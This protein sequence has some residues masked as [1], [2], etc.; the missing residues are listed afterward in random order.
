[1]TSFLNLPFGLCC[2]IFL[3]TQAS[4]A[5]SFSDLANDLGMNVQFSS[6][7]LMGGGC[8]WFDFDNDGFEDIYIT[9]GHNEDAL[10]KNNGNGT[11]TNVIFEAGFLGTS[12]K[13]TLGVVTGDID[14]DGFREVFVTTQNSGLGF[15]H[16]ENF[17]FYNNGDG[18]F[19]DIT[20]SAGLEE[21]KW[22]FSATF[23]D[24]NGDTYLDLFVGNYIETP[25]VLLDEFNN[26][27]GFGHDCYLDDLYINQGDLTF[28]NATEDMQAL[29]IGCCLA[30]A[31]TDYDGDGDIDLMAANDFG[32]WV[33]PS[34]LFEN[35]QEYLNDVSAETT[36]DVEIYGMGIAIGDFDEDLD[37]DYYSTNI[38]AN[39]LLQQMESGEFQDVAEAMAATDEIAGEGNAVGWGTFFFDYNN[40][41][42]LDLFVSNGH[43]PVVSWLENDDAQNNRLFQGNEGGVFT[44]A[45]N[46]LPT[47]LF[48]SRGCAFAD[49]DKDGDL[50]FG[51]VSVHQLFETAQDQFALYH[52]ENELGNFIAFDLEGLVCNRDAFGTQVIV[53]TDGRAFLR[54]VGGGSSHCSQNSSILH[55]GL[56]TIESLDSV[57]VNWPIGP[58]QVFDSLAVNLF[59]EILQ[60]TTVV[61]EPQDT[62][63]TGLTLLAESMKIDLFPNPAYDKININ[64][65]GIEGGI[66]I[67]IMD[68]HG[69]E[70]WNLYRG[71]VGIIPKQFQIIDQIA[72]GLYLCVITTQDGKK[73]AVKM[74]EL[75]SD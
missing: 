7:T 6:Q 32:E 9:G 60:D 61:V 2:A 41:T 45:S 21:T 67:S 29:N 72:S 34:K 50:D 10:F 69:R 3:S 33:E 35:D 47:N 44:D 58:S 40:D 57:V 74:I 51:V 25:L 63:V 27:V 15:N 65:E 75:I 70:I 73:I 19:S 12:D 46:E 37:L 42:Y 54:E 48:R 56:G 49:Y 5:Q 4:N 71:E 59:H 30:V 36:C 23:L 16:V 24:V 62:V 14:N 13:N 1:M 20:E 28:T 18:T 53:H 11:F 68:L 31:A 64:V 55:F 38:G 39:V 17:L 43:I 52:N 66:D 8:A 22:A 26:P